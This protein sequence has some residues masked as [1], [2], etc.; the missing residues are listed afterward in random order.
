MCGVEMLDLAHGQVE[1]GHVVLDF[2]GRLGTGHAHGG[3]QATVDFEDSELVEDGRVS[4]IFES[5]EWDNL[6]GGRRL[7]AVPDT[8][9][10]E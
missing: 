4:G 1:E 6:V 10:Q 3:T 7:D 9:K 2:E 5:I 8:V